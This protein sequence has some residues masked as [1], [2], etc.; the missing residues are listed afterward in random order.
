MVPYRYYHVMGGKSQQTTGTSPEVL[1]RHLQGHEWWEPGNYDIVA[2]RD[3][4]PPP[5]SPGDH[6]GVVVKHADGRVELIPDRPA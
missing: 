6:W 4:Q 5:R 3:I 2:S 1:R